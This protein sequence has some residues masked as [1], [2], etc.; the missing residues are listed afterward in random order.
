MSGKAR[1]RMLHRVLWCCAALAMLLPVSATR[2]HAQATSEVTDRTYP[3]WMTRW[4][5]LSELGSL[6][7]TLPSTHQ[8]QPLLF[9]PAPLV[10]MLWTAGN[11][12]GAATETRAPRS[13]YAIGVGNEDGALRR[14][15]DPLTVSDVQARADGWR[16]LGARGGAIGSVRF[17]QSSLDPSAIGVI[18]EPYATPRLLPVDTSSEPL[19]RI[20]ARLEG[21]AG[22]T[23]RGWALGGALGYDTRSTT[24]VNAAFVRRN[25]VVLP[26][27]RLGISRDMYN[28]RLRLGAHV[29]GQV[30]EEVIDLTAV[31]RAGLLYQLEGYR[32]VPGSGVL[33]QPYYQRISRNARTAVASVGGRTSATEWTA[34]AGGVAR[35]DRFTSTR[36]NDPPSNLWN[37]AGFDAGASARHSMVNDRVWLSVNARI[38]KLTGD[39][40]FVREE[41]A[42]LRTD[43][44]RI[45]TSAEARVR[46]GA[47]NWTL[48]IR[49]SLDA[50][51]RMVDDSIAALQSDVSALSPGIMLEGSRALTPSLHAVG[52]VTYVRYAGTGTIPDPVFY[53]PLY[54]RLFAPELDI[55]TST[56]STSGLVLGARWIRP[57]GYVLW[58]AA[59]REQRTLLS[60]DRIFTPRGNRTVSSLT[61]GVTVR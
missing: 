57:D 16:A 9:T 55:A 48:A 34:F 19:R 44:Q 8:N 23:V 40:T 10:G 49:T 17:S 4:S 12:A 61:L 32:T 58:L 60:R 22:W 47:G 29:S 56:L 13:E 52:G 6:T 26:A 50:E 30:G 21:A 41:P 28:G 31:G 7:R 11:P 45:T 53:S 5:P 27:G 43:E 24:S 3:S 46:S 36:A 38:V 18:N 42:S 54:Q 2:V 20:S 1:G 59:R 25:R 37:S 35:E 51:Q 15:L 14:P 33:S 39:A